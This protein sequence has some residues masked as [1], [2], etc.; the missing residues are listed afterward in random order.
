MSTAVFCLNSQ[1]LQF[2]PLPGKV[3]G[4]H[5]FMTR[6]WKR[7]NIFLIWLTKYWL[8]THHR[9]DLDPH[10]HHQRQGEDYP[11]HYLER[12]SRAAVCGQ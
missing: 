7:I 5:T 9:H 11:W 2:P 6:K 10:H 3:L 8:D 12:V 1:S 4:Q